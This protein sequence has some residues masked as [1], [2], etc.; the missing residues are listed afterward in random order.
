MFNFI[1][2]YCGYV[3]SCFAPTKSFKTATDA[4]SACH[5][6]Y[7]LFN[8][9]IEELTGDADP[10]LTPAHIT[11]HCTSLHIQHRFTAPFHHEG[12]GV[13]EAFH[14]TLGNRVTAAYDAAPWTPKSLW[15]YACALVSLQYN[16]I[17]NNKCPTSSPYEMFTTKLPNV[18]MRPLLPFGTPMEVLDNPHTRKWPFGSKTRTVMYIGP[19]HRSSHSIMCYDPRLKQIL[20]RRSFQALDRVP[21]DW[22]PLQS[23]DHKETDIL[24]ESADT[25]ILLGGIDDTD[26]I[27]I[28]IPMERSDDDQSSTTRATEHNVPP[29]A[30]DEDDDT[31][32]GPIAATSPPLPLTIVVD[33]S[34]AIASISL[35]LPLLSLIHISEPTRPY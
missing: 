34:S 12:V 15:T 18:N 3:Y 32:H 25:P 5:A 29:L 4:I 23:T 20:T 35:P 21:S 33:G 1:D 19:S 2:R 9:P 17:P 13:V 28:S 6:H 22:I 8:H 16:F 27:S 26:P 24:F 30:V 7:A 14:R 11:D 10:I 31:I